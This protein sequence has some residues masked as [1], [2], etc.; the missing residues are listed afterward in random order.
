MGERVSAEQIFEAL[1]EE[2]Q[3]FKNRQ[4][5]NVYDLWILSEDEDYIYLDTSG[6]TYSFIEQ[7][8]S[9]RKGWQE[10]EM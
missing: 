2:Y 7:K 6:L 10:Q 5:Y 9:Q 4:G 8:A 3:L 1:M